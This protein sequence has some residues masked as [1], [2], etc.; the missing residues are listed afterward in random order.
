MAGKFSSLKVGTKRG[1]D[2]N[3]EINL[4]QVEYWTGLQCTRDELAG[5]FRISPECLEAKLIENYGMGWEEF[6]EVYSADGK[7]SLRRYQ[8]NL[9]KVNSAMAIWLGKQWL[10]QKDSRIEDLEK[11]FLTFRDFIEEIANTSK[12]LVNVEAQRISGDA[13]SA[14]KDKASS[15]GPALANKSPIQNRRK[16]RGQDPV[17]A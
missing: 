1:Y 13:A 5:S 17:P 6:R 15:N 2:P 3:R 10:G 9:A 14:E 11:G 4:D 8:F 16:K 7:M 12:G